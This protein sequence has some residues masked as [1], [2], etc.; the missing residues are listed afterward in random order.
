MPILHPAYSYKLLNS[1]NL[2]KK[3]KQMIKAS[4]SK[5][6]YNTIKEQLRE[7]FTNNVDNLL[8]KNDLSEEKIEVGASNDVYYAKEYNN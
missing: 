4:V 3:Q 6:D 7:V 5:I 2:S 1:A 8:P